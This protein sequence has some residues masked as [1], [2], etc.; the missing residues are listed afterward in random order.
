MN[1]PYKV[2][3]VSRN[4]S[5]EEIKNAYRNQARWINEAGGE[6]MSAKM[7]ELNNA[8]DSIINDR[9]SASSNN[10]YRNTY[11]GGN[12]YYHTSG[13]YTDIRSLL[14]TNRL[15]EA[16][17]LLD[18]MPNSSRDAEWY[19][20]KG[21]LLQKKGWLEDAYTHYSTAC[22]MDPNNFEYRN[23]LNS[24]SSYNN[25]GGYNGSYRTGPAYN[26]NG[27][28]SGCDVCT[29]LLCADC[30]CECMGGDLIRCC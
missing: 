25:R 9:R 19:Y 5:E 20:L 21:M 18:G 14:N 7:D 6:N 17:Q 13:N 3:G 2:L 10:S 11:N 24:M 15:S 12:N 29:S 16:E 4:A 8:Y 28:C 26:Q 27:G 23:A 1:D 22:R 30:C